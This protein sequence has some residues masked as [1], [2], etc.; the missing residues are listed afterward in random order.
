MRILVT[1]AGG[2]VGSTLA[3]LGGSELTPAT[4]QQLDITDTD[5]LC[6]I[7]DVLR[8]DAVINAAAQANVDRAE[9]DPEHSDEVN[10]HAV[11]RMAAAC[12]ARKIRLVHISTDY[13]LDNPELDELTEDLVPRP[14]SVYARS[15]LIGEAAAVAEGAAV[16]RVQWVYAPGERGFF[17]AALRRLEAGQ[18]LSLVVDQVGRPTPAALVARGLLAVARAGPGGLFHLACGGEVSA[19]DWIAAAAAA[20]GLSVAGAS[21][22][23]RAVLGG[24]HRPARSCLN[25]DRFAAAWGVR[26][27]AWDVALA[28]AMG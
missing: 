22:T 23:T 5:A 12:A 11:A 20:R 14:R 7:L 25:S 1:G 21:E 17:N 26:L 27:P 10:G 28:A 24:A 4:R 8:P 6:A 9:V 3:Q 15:K 16:V 2:L 13:V 18:P 19:H